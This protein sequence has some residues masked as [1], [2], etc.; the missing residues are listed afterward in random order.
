MQRP[1]IPNYYW[2][3]QIPSLNV[4]PTTY[5]ENSISPVTSHS[6][7][8]NTASTGSGEQISTLQHIHRPWLDSGTAM[9]LSKKPNFSSES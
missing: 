6:S 9:D 7:S 3:S 5:I 8:S 1:L 4:E 2:H